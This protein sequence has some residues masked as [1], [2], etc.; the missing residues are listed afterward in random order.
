MRLTFLC[1]NVCRDQL[2]DTT[3]SLD[4]TG[5]GDEGIVTLTRRGEVYWYNNSNCHK[6]KCSAKTIVISTYRNSSLIPMRLA[7]SRSRP[8]QP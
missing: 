2:I 1:V 8:A 6:L 5:D 4:D 7:K 3:G